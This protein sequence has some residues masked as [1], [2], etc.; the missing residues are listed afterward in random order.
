MVLERLSLAAFAV[1]FL[2]QYLLLI[3]GSQMLWRKIARKNYAN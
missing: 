1:P 2:W 3:F